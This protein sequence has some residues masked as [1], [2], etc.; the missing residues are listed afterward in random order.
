MTDD[1][2]VVLWRLHNGE[3]DQ[4]GVPRPAREAGQLLVAARD[5]NRKAAASQSGDLFAVLP[6][7]E[8]P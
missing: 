3:W 2:P 4:L 5:H 8:R 7:G 6:V 1:R